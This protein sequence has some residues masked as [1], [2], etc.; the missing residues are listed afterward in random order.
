MQYEELE[1]PILSDK[2]IQT[3]PGPS[4]KPEE[5]QVKPVHTATDAAYEHGQKP[6]K[7]QQHLPRVFHI[8]GLKKSWES[9]DV[10]YDYILVDEKNDMHTTTIPISL[11]AQLF[12]PC[13][14]E[15]DKTGVVSKIFP[16]PT[17]KTR[18]EI[19]NDFFEIIKNPPV[20]GTVKSIY[21][22]GIL[23]VAT[24]T[25]DVSVFGHLLVDL[26]GIRKGYHIK[27]FGYMGEKNG[28]KQ[29]DATIIVGKE[30]LKK[31]ESSSEPDPHVIV[32]EETETNTTA[33]KVD[34]VEDIILP[35]IDEIAPISF[36]G[37]QEYNLVYMLKNYVATYSD[38]YPEYCFQNGIAMLSTITRRR[39][40]IGI[41]GR[42][43]FTNVWTLNLGQS[44]Y[45]RKGILW[46]YQ[47]MLREAVGDTFLPHDTTPE[48][49]IDIMADK[50]ET[51]GY[52][53]EAGG[54]VK[55]IEFDSSEHPEKIRKAVCSLWKDEAGQFYADLNKPHKQ[56]LPIM[57]RNYPGNIS[58]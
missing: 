47:T 28:K 44:G 8:V 9:D 52:D 54:H 34:R 17:K 37:L 39:L 58:S 4:K 41:N 30:Y 38:A 50:I 56:A 42:Y 1:S 46:F 19:I 14:I 22:N 12:E 31:P 35:K 5:N 45:A 32:K 29:C 20:E 40:K 55:K 21:G 27:V 6:T 43:E 33:I 25:G 16:C 51:T 48:G 7:M 3:M 10:T 53:K 11:N 24:A 49:L 18:D 26:M 15:V 13:T 23:N 36:R 2:S 57:K